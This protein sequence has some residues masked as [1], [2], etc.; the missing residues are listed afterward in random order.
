MITMTPN[1]ILGTKESFNIRCTNKDLMR[2]LFIVFAI[3]FT[4]QIQAQEIHEARFYPT[5][6]YIKGAFEVK[7]FNN[8]YTEAFRDGA[9]RPDTR[10][11]FHSSFLTVLIGT[12]KNLNYGV[13]I[14]YRSAAT[15]PDKNNRF[16]AFPLKNVSRSNGNDVD[17]RYQGLSAI[18]PRI[19]YSLES[20]KGA[21]SVLHAVYFPTLK[22]SEGNADYGFSDWEHLQ[23]YNNIYF[24]RKVDSQSNIFVDLGLH[25]ENLGGF[26]FNEESGYAQL[27]TPVT[28]IYNFY[29]SWKTTFYGMINLTPR[30]GFNDGGPSTNIAGGA[31]S[32]LGLGAKRFIR[33]W[34]EVELLYTQ[35]FNFGSNSSASTMNLGFRYSQN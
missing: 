21:F 11:D 3:F 19:K 18:G 4:I 9:L 17:F 7:L 35:F 15:S 20:Q 5:R 14:K 32:Q 26:L 1:L 28:F 8:Y 10:Q 24:E 33:P 2:K 6:L 27:L 30:F 29:P 12:N 34:L 31:F 23:F 22:E 16:I 13:D 25:F